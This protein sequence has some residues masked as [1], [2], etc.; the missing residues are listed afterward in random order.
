LHAQSGSEEPVE[1][2]ESSLEKA[3]VE[4]SPAL[5]EHCFAHYELVKGEEG[6]PIELG[7]GAMGVTYKAP[8]SIF[9]ARLRLTLGKSGDSY[10]YAI[11]FVEGEPLDQVFRRSCC[12]ASIYLVRGGPDRSMISP[13]TKSIYMLPTTVP[14]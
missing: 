10:F 14:R 11:E 9:D 13:A 6:K 3:S 5:Q 4:S 12:Y 7:H 8:M 1:S 2:D